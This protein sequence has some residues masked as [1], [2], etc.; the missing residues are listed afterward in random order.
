M[1][2]RKSTAIETVAL[3]DR[4]NNDRF[5]EYETI[6]ACA[7]TSLVLRGI[8]YMGICGRLEPKF[9]PA[10]ILPGQIDY[11]SKKP[12]VTPKRI[13][14]LKN[15]R[16]V[17]WCDLESENETVRKYRDRVR[18]SS[19]MGLHRLGAERKVDVLKHQF[20][21]WV[22]TCLM[23]VTV[24]ASAGCSSRTEGAKAPDPTTCL[25]YTSPSPRD[26]QKSRMPSSA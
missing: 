17:L 20:A 12:A 1:S 5:R 9:D 19:S 8:R 26:R 25:L 15:V 7:G 13:C 6:V 2:K 11:F 10:L 22:T 14:T 21:I 23:A 4:L 18:P 16:D 3:A 24:S